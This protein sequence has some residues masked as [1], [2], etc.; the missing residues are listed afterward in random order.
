MTPTPDRHFSRLALATG[1]LAALVFA[2]APDH[3]LAEAPP[4]TAIR[5]TAVVAVGDPTAAA[6]RLVDVAQQAGGY[7]SRRGS[8]GVTLRVPPADVDRLLEEAASLGVLVERTYAAEDLGRA[9][10]EVRAALETR[11]EGLEDF[12]EVLAESGGNGVVELERE[13]LSLVEQIEGLR[14]RIR[15]MEHRISFASVEISFRFHERRTPAPD[16]NS[17]FPWLNTVNLLDLLDD[18]Q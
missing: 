16:G 5:A 11:E 3:A 10:V 7:F 9:L 14:G 2:G 1:V 8:E 15:V 17:S 12:F 6:D 4:R 13:I 18:F